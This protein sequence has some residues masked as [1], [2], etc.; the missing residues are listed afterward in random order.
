MCQNGASYVHVSTGILKCAFLITRTSIKQDFCLLN[1]EINDMFSASHPDSG[2]SA[3]FDR[4]IFFSLGLLQNVCI[5][6]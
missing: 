1:T 2:L 6:Y 5:V 3:S 4:F